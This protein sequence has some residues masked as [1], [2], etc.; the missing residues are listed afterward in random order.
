MSTSTIQTPT[1][2]DGQRPGGQTSPVFEDGAAFD[3]GVAGE[4]AARMVGVLNEA[5]LALMISIGHR[6]GLFDVLAALPASTADQIAD[7]ASLQERYVREWLA[8]LTTARVVH[9]DRSSG[10]YR[11]P[12]EYAASLTRT[13]GPD[14]LARVMQFVPLLAGVEEHIVRCFRTG[15]GVPYS[16]YSRFHQLMGEDTAALHDAALI[17]AIIP[18]VPGLTDRLRAGIDVADIGCGEGHAM[19]L[20]AAAFPASQ[21]TG[22]D[23]SAEAVKSAQREAEQRGLANVTFLLRD[24]TELDQHQAYDVVTAFDAIHDQAQPA[25]VLAGIAAALRPGGVFLMVDID[26]SSELPDNLEHP[27]G[28]FLYCASTL[29]CM[30]VSL[31]LGGVGLGTMWG[32]QQALSMLRAAGFADVKIETVDPDAFNAYYVATKS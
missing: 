7:A 10:T 11:L 19:N 13:A 17:D 22:Y 4:F 8:A 24:V 15:G 5:S 27:L 21:F 16:A 29:H 28:T 26:A 6:V 1:S 32:R 18:L 31:G 23:F 14:N 9:Y 25:Q 3:N 12:M 30:T 2:Q 20:L